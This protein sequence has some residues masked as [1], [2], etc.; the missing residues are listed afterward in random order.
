[1]KKPQQVFVDSELKFGASTR[2]YII[3]ERPQINKNFPSIL[4][5]SEEAKNADKEETSFISLPESEIKLDVTIAI[6]YVDF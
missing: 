6:C 1:L 3:R 2:T 5:N 4:S